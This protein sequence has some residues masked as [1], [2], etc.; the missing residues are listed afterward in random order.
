MFGF[1]RH[2]RKNAGVTIGGHSAAAPV[3]MKPAARR[4][5]DQFDGVPAYSAV[6]TTGSRAVMQLTLKGPLDTFMPPCCSW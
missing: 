4:A 6:L 2:E 3:R 5:I 1:T